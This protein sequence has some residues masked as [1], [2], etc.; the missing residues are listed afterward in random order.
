MAIVGENGAGKSTLVKLLLKLYEPT[1]G[2]IAADGIRLADL[3]TDTWQARCTAT[4]QDF[5]KF[6]LRAG[7]IV[8]VGDL[9]RMGDDD[10]VLAA[11]RTVDGT[12]VPASLA[13]GIDRPVGLTFRGGRDLSG[14]QWQ[15]LALARG[16]LR[17]QPLAVALDEPTASLDARAEA[18]LFSR[19]AQ[20]AGRAARAD[21]VTI[22]VS[23][24]FPSARIADLIVVVD[25]GT[26]AEIGNHES[27]LALGGS[28]AEMFE[29]LARAYRDVRGTD[30]GPAPAAAGV[31]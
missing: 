25:Q 10:A 16:A 30:G 29:L 1:S 14:G 2:T 26:I 19:L 24:R 15:K 31:S 12:D 6:E 13:A 28:Y 5:V 3:D 27:L 17:E 20:A 11:L 7:H 4:F 9:P 18:T 21:A 22:F 8:G 23:H